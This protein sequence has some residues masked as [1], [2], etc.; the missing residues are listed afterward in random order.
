MTLSYK[1]NT[2]AMEAYAEMQRVAKI[3]NKSLKD[4]AT[5]MGFDCPYSW[6]Q[7]LLKTVF[8]QKD[9]EIENEDAYLLN[10]GAD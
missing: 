5:E 9:K 4:T 10:M 2:P 7:A 3:L 6:Q 1:P 8:K